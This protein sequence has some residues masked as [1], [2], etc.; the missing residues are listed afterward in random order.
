M[1]VV[2]ALIS[3]AL[4]L[5]GCVTPGP[6][7]VA[8][9]PAPVTAAGPRQV[10]LANPGFEADPAPQYR[11][12]PRWSCTVH[13]NPDAFRFTVDETRPAAGKRSMKVEPGTHKEPWALTMQVLQD[14]SALHGARVR[15]S[16][17]V[18]LEGFEGKGVGPMAIA[19]YPHGSN[20]GHWQTQATGTS[21]WKR[22]E[23]EFVVP[24]EAGLLEVGAI[25]EGSGKAW[26]DEAR[27]EVL[28][29]AASRKNPV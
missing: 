4:F 9:S 13:N 15:L 29:P 7:Q 23:V 6:Q 8:G 10:T 1:K 24:K 22:V 27:L 3:A 17:A 2:L 18:R 20:M 26:I 14:L 28:E 21:D 16:I 5:L 25:I 11:C 19:Q 12:P